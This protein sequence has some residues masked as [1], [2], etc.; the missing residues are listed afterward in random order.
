MNSNI[1]IALFRGINVGGKNILP[2]KELAS[3]LENLGCKNVRTYIQSGN[4]VFQISESKA[5]NLDKKIHSEILKSH[6]IDT[7][8]LLLNETEFLKVVKNNPFKTDDG[9]RLHIY[10]LYTNSSNP[11]LEKINNLKSKTERYLLKEKAFYL[12]APDGIGR[13]KL[14]SNVE[15]CLGVKV[16]ARNYNT[17]NKLIVM[18][19]Q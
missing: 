19:Q 1:Y 3:I 16:T 9:K 15:K 4:V 2:M 18:L 10:F 5:K 6:N 8:V 17:I 13:S 11:D 14:A 7:K 12:Y